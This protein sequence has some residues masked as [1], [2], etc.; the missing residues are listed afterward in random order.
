MTR[1]IDATLKTVARNEPHYLHCPGAEKFC[2]A[3]KGLDG[4]CSGKAA[5]F[6]GESRN[7]DEGLHAHVINLFYLADA[8]KCETGRLRPF[9]FLIAQFDFLE[10]SI[11][12][13][14]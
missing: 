9:V 11:M 2:A 3:I 10:N 7:L 4:P 1:S 14:W 13:A 6:P 8:F 5:C 12:I